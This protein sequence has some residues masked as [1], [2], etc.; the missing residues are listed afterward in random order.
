MG[1]FAML[2]FGLVL[3]CFFVLLVFLIGQVNL[4]VKEKYKDKQRILL[5][6][7]MAI[8]LF[9]S[10]L[11]PTGIVNY[12]RFESESVLI[13]QREGVAN[14]MTTLKLK[15]NKKF[16]EKNVCFGISETTGTYR[17]VNDTIYFENVSLGPHEAKFYE[18]ATISSGKNFE[19]HN[20]EIL[21][22]ENS[23]D[24]TGTALWIVKNELKNQKALLQWP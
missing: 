6:G 17:V 18:F 21:R 10:F 2:V 16:I 9:T 19:T 7:I 14:C 13:A 1:I 24:T 22:F 12:E 20:E 4:L 3:I 23:S 8:V 11:F 5:V 15:K